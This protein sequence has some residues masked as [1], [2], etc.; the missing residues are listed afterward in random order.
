MV[1]KYAPKL[2]I[3]HGLRF[4]GEWYL[5]KKKCNRLHGEICILKNYRKEMIWGTRYDSFL[6]A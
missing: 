4:H 5:L 3:I 6:K 1:S 2:T